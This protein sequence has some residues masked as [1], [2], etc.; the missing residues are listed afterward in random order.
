MDLGPWLV[1]GIVSIIAAIS[2]ALAARWKAELE[3]TKTEADTARQDSTS[4]A[5]EKR[6]EPWAVG[7][8]IIVLTAVDVEKI[9]GVICDE[10]L[11]KPVDLKDLEAAI[12]RVTG[13]VPA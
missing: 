13:K 7:T 5:V 4:R 9:D 2:S 1:A 12:N 11:V 3:K 8:G 10:M 6:Q